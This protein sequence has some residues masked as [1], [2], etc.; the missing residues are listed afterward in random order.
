MSS[1]N[2]RYIVSVV[3]VIILA[4]LMVNLWPSG[5]SYAYRQVKSI[6]PNEQ[7]QQLVIDRHIS[8]SPRPKE[9]FTCLNL[10]KS[11]KNNAID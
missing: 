11:M 10:S 2:F 8:L 7:N 4:N 3:F 9:S 5:E 6:A 1:K